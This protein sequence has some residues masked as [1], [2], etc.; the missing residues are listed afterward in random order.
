MKKSINFWSFAAG[1]T[2]EEAILLA[3]DAGFAGIELS[4]GEVGLMGL[5]TPNAAMT[6]RKI[7]ESEGIALPSL[8]CGLCWDA[9][10]TSS[11]AQKRQEAKDMIRRQV[12]MAAE[13]GADSIL[14]IPGA[15]GV[16]FL[17]GKENLLP[18]DAAYDTALEAIFELAPYAEN[19]RVNLA[20]ENVWNKFLLSPLE[21]RDFIDKVGSDYVGSYF[22]VGNVLL[23]GYPE[24]WVR[25]L[26]K[27]I[28]KVHFKD[29]RR[30]PGGFN[31]FCDLLSGD[32]DY[33]AVIEALEA[34]GYDDYCAAEMIPNYT[35]YSS[36][37][38]YNASKSMDRILNKA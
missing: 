36:Q 3:K 16:D 13:L 17:N 21:L 9:L 12:D 14:V 30:N 29:Y 22:D 31:C 26:G 33:P 20:L 37:T 15:V 18:Y 5:P 2:V 23:T 8:A 4:M 24:Q 10:L 6:A 1:T 27:R 19:A 34:V 25:I 7:A 32:V 35:H 11:I 38:I 28:K